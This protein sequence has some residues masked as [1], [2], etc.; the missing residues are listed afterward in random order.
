MEAAE[1]FAGRLGLA[2]V[3]EGAAKGEGVAPDVEERVPDFLRGIV[4]GQNQGAGYYRI[5][6]G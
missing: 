5:L 2:L 3:A 1:L 6:L 4:C